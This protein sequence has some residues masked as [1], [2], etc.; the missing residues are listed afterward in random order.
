MHGIALPLALFPPDQVEP[1][2]LYQR[3]GQV[4][5]RYLWRHEPRVIPVAWEGRVQLLRWG[6]RRGEPGGLPPTGWPRSS[7]TRWAAGRRGD[8]S[9]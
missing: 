4:E 1:A 3:D 7:P 5:A 2:H 8:P 9:R 6:A